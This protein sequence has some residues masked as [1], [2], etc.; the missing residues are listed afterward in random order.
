M[1]GDLGLSA[2]SAVALYSKRTWAREVSV[3]R[4]QRVTLDT[5]G[6]LSIHESDRLLPSGCMSPSLALVTPLASD[7]PNTLDADNSLN[8]S[9]VIFIIGL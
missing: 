4:G 3:I 9:A 6:T 5:D 2:F 7:R 1:R 8:L